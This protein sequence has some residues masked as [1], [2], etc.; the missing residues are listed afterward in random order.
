MNTGKVFLALAVLCVGGI[1]ATA[2]ADVLYECR[3]GTFFIEE[4][5]LG[6]TFYKISNGA[7][8]DVNVIEIN[9]HSV[10]F[11]PKG[12][13]GEVGSERNNVLNRMS[14]KIRSWLGGYDSTCKIIKK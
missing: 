11:L 2:K 6:D 5:W 8:V 14:G 1:S 10:S 4:S 9:E 7:R 3:R 12:E 13:T